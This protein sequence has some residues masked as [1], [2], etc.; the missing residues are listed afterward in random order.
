[1]VRTLDQAIAQISPLPA[2]DQKEIG[3]KLLS[4][5]ERL[6]IFFARRIHDM[7]EHKSPVIW[8]PEAL[9]DIDRLWDHY[10]E[11]AGNS[12]GGQD[13][14]GNREDRRSR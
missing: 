2:A 3:R 14:A 8:S 1:M 5:V 4:H 7:A 13:P 12:G 11:A 6:K 10:A 9:D